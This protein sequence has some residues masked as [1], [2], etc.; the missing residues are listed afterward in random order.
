MPTYAPCGDTPASSLPRTMLDAFGTSRTSGLAAYAGLEAAFR[1]AAPDRPLAWAYTSKIIRKRS[2]EAGKPVHG[3]RGALRALAA[4]GVNELTVQSLHVLAGEEFSQMERMLLAGALDDP[5]RF[6]AVL[7]GRPLLETG[8]DMEQAVAAVLDDIPP[9]RRADE[10][11][12]L[13]A[14]GHEHRRGD[15]VLRAVADHVQR[16]DPLAWMASVEGALGFDQVLRT[17]CARQ[18]RRVWL[19]PFMVVAGEHARH[20]MLGEHDASWASRLKAAG[21]DVVGRMRG[22]GEL[23]GIQNLFLSHASGA[24]D[25]ICKLKDAG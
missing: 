18:I 11:I 24:Y 25:N 3:I 10:A 2:T 20:D 22:L 14:H 15:L 6:T 12:V 5:G 21:M 8:E 17:L 4:Q 16:R 1:A 13:M 9:E 19:Q 23:P 7:V